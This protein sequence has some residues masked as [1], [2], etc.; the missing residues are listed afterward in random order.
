VNRGTVVVDIWTG[1]VGSSYSGRS[2]QRA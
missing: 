2:S 1:T